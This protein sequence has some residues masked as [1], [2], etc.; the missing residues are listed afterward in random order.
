MTA[1]YFT[2]LDLLF[3]L[4][5]NMRW[6]SGRHIHIC[7]CGSLEIYAWCCHARKQQFYYESSMIED[8][9]WSLSDCGGKG[10]SWGWDSCCIFSCWSQFLSIAAAPVL[11]FFHSCYSLHSSLLFSPLCFS[12]ISL[13]LECGFCTKL[14]L[15][16]TEHHDFRQKFYLK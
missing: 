13:V 4:P 5:S 16:L 6:D 2:H 14:C 15:S 8:N 3:Q 1:Y 12:A 9:P 7:P 10:L 11:F